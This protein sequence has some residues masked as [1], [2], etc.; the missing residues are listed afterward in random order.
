MTKKSGK[1][2]GGARKKNAPWKTTFG[3]P[4]S[5]VPVNYVE[6]TQEPMEEMSD[7]F[8]EAN[9]NRTDRDMPFSLWRFLLDLIGL[10][11]GE[12]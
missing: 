11:K 6:M 2:G 7:T 10:A 5:K 12:R 3:Q 9:Q 1:R 8:L 4:S